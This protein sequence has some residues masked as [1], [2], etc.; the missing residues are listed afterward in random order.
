MRH[1]CWSKFDLVRGTWIG[2]SFCFLEYSVSIRSIWT[3]VSWCSVGLVAVL[4]FWVLLEVVLKVFSCN[5]RFCISPLVL[6]NFASGLLVLLLKMFGYVF[7]DQFCPLVLES[8]ILHLW[9]YSFLWY[10]LSNTE[11]NHSNFLLISINTDICKN[12]FYIHMENVL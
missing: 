8:A 6:S 10:I 9:Q 5:Y 4:S 7:L 12:Y 3:A 2:C 1:F 11:K